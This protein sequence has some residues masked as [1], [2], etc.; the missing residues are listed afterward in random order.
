MVVVV[1]AAAVRSTDQDTGMGCCI[2]GCTV[3]CT[4]GTVAAAELRI[5]EVAHCTVEAVE[6]KDTALVAGRI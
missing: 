5:V 6:R 2:V 4:V 3:D 1:A